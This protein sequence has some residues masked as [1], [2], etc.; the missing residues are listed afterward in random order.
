[1]LCRVLYYGA[2]LSQIYSA[3]FLDMCVCVMLSIRS[4][5]PTA[6]GSEKWK[7]WKIKK[8]SWPRSEIWGGGWVIGCHIRFR[9]VF[10][11]SFGPEF[12]AGYRK[13]L[14]FL[15]EPVLAEISATP[16]VANS[17]GA[18]EFTPPLDLEMGG[19]TPKAARL[20]GKAS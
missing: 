1:M 14:G 19:S 16:D 4:F 17:Y 12:I 18:L 2:P 9:D 11:D 15:I 10:E 5:L 13:E 7:K 3:F 6:E 20:L 8:S